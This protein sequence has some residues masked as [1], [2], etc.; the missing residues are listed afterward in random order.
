MRPANAARAC[1]ACAAEF[2]WADAA[3]E[4]GRPGQT[5]PDRRD[6][7]DPPGEQAALRALP[8]KVPRGL[9]RL[10][11]GRGQLLDGRGGRSGPRPDRFRQAH[12]RRAALC[13]PR[14]GLFRR[15]RWHCE[16][17]P[18]GALQLGGAAA[19]G[20]LLLRVSD[21]HREHPQRDVLA[22]DR[23]LRQGQQGEGE[24]VQRHRD[25]A[26]RRQEGQ[27]G[28]AL[29]H[30]VEAVC[31]AAGRVRGGRGHLLL[32]LVLRHLLAQE[33]RAHARADLLQRAHLARRGHALRLCVPALLDAREQAHGRGAAR[34]RG[35][36]GRAREGV[37]VR[38]AAR[39]PDRHEPGHDVDVH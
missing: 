20:A 4:H 3:S 1:G 11:E 12:R 17:E 22:A 27:L 5:A 30:R 25:G 23:H 38:R 33:A 13:D 18:R 32:G 39:Q 24:A 9:A 6:R 2:P 36:R 31:R 7:A 26:L 10:Q 8:D 34:H 21:C 28:P 29:D 14:A 16:R 19:R 37:C 15:R 35:R